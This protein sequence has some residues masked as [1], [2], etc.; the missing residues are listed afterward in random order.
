MLQQREETARLTV[1]VNGQA[2]G[3][4]PTE[5]ILQAAL[6]EGMAF[7]YS[8]RVGGCASCKC[9]LVDGQVKELTETT[10]ILS[11]EDLDEGFILACQSVPRTNVKI[12]VDLPEQ[13]ARRRVAGKVVAQERLTHDIT[14]LRL[15]LDEP[16]DYKPGQFADLAFAALPGISRSY[17]FAT[18]PGADGV[19]EFFVRK[20]PGGCSRPGPTTV[21]SSARP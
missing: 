10:Y 8:C 3:I 18:P 13:A 20:V 12:A 6:R 16:L 19:V 14:R 1:E 11:D 17:S 21:M 7:P 2:I 5:T 15:A 9:K 4:E